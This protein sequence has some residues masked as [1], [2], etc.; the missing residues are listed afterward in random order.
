MSMLT[1]FTKSGVPTYTF[2]PDL[3]AGQDGYVLAYNDTTKVVEAINDPATAGANASET[4]SWV[5]DGNS[6]A[7]AAVNT[8][9]STVKMVGGQSIVTLAVAQPTAITAGGGAGDTITATLPASIPKPKISLNGYVIG[10]VFGVDNALTFNPG[11]V[12][13]SADGTKITI[14]LQNAITAGAGCTFRSFVVTWI[15][16]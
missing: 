14:R 1:A 9:Y 6:D 16:A 10:S 11:I 12:E 3:G 2:K 13:S 15:S 5:I 4:L 7:F 8:V